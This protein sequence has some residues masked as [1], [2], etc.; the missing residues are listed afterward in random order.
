MAIARLVPSV[1]N[2]AA[3][4][5]YL[6]VTDQDRMFTN[7][8]S[9]TYGTVTNIYA[10]TN[11]RYVYLR[12]F[13]FTSIPDDAIVSSFTIKLKANESGINTSSNYRPRICNNTTTLTGSSSTIGTSANVITFTGVTADWATI[14]DDYGSNFGI[15]VNVRR[16]NSRTEG[17]VNIY[18]A[19]IEVNYTVP[20][21]HSV[22]ITNSTSATVTA[23]D[24]NPLEGTDVTITSN[25]LSGINVTDNNVDVTNQF[26]QVTSGTEN[27]VPSSNTN[28]NFSITDIDNAYD[29]YDS[30]TSATL[31][32]SG[33]RTGT[34]YLNF[35]T[36]SIPSGATINSVS[37]KVTTQFSRNNSSSGF[38]SSMQMY[39][40][41]TAK[42]SA[43]QWVSSATDVSQTTYTLTVGSWTSSELANARL[44]LTATNNASSTV[45]Y[46]YV[47]GATL[48]VEYVFNGYVYTISNIVA[49]HSIV[50]SVNVSTPPTITVGTPSRSIISAL[51]GYDQCVCTF[52]SDMALQAWEA[53]A[54]KSGTTP[55]RGVGLL[56]ESGTTLAA[57]A[58]GT[59]YVDNEELTNGDG[60]YTITVYGQSTQGVWSE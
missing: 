17:Y 43:T 1:L 27:C 38:T 42:G 31:S 52:T 59:V 49:D 34:L 19:E 30:A 22:T 6:T 44:Y 60:E 26:Q 18:G 3:G 46:I 2:N 12:G 58:T 56:V 55:A 25:T 33:G 20:V 48:T 41:T 11:S 51:S 8:D 50:V 28:S 5:T 47:Y 21:H 10:S 45:R 29:G 14:V 24:T 15:R 4:T 36:A 32:L 9:T 7:T 35:N 16:A 57:S 39:S 37:C 40:G 54:T 23:S 53:R 13:N